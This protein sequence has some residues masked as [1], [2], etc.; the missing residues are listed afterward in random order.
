MDLAWQYHYFSYNVINMKRERSTKVLNHFL[1]TLWIR[2]S[3]ISSGLIIQ[4]ML[5]GYV[6]VNGKRM[7]NPVIN[8]AEKLAGIILPGKY[9]LVCILYHKLPCNYTYFL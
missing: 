6:A 5:P 2:A 1:R 8:R 7:S 3:K 4:V 9:W